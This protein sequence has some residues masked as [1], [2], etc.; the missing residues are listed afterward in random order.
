MTEF[1]FEEAEDHEPSQELNLKDDDF[2][3]VFDLKFVK[4]QNVSSIAFFVEENHGGEFT[5]INKLELYGIPLHQ[6]NM[7][8]LKKAD[9]DH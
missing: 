8:E 5:R 1:G 9:H 6:T 4:F 3:N 2:G 7:K